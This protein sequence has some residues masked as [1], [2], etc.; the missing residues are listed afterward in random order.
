MSGGRKDGPVRLTD[1]RRRIL[2]GIEQR[3]EMDLQEIGTEFNSQPRGVHFKHPAAATRFGGMLIAPMRRAGWVANGEQ[4][5]SY[6]WKI[7]VTP[8]GLV[9]ARVARREG[10]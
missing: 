4:R 9:A 3:G 10:E 6:R 8:T 1:L 7:K 5:F 2:L